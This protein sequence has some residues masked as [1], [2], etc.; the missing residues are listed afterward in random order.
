MKKA[1]SFLL[2]VLMCLTMSACGGG[3]DSSSSNSGGRQE[4]TFFAGI[5]TD[6]ADF[7]QELVDTYNENQGKVDGVY[8]NYKPKASNY[9]AD[10]STVFAGTSVPDVITLSDQYFKGY[11]KQNYLYNIDEL[12]KASSLDLNKMPKN[13][14]AR[15]RINWETKTA[16]NDNDPL[17]GVP[18]GSNPTFLYYNVDAFEAEKI[19]II[20]ISEEDLDNYNSSNSTSYMPH[21][22]AEYSE[23]PGNGLV[24]ST[25][26]NG[27]TVYK[28]FNNQIPMN[29]SELVNISKYLTKSY[30]PNSKTTYGFLSEW[31]FSHGWSVGGDCMNWD[32]SANQ[33]VFTLGNE[34]TNYLVTKDTTI[35]GH[36][37]SAGDILS[38]ADKKYFAENGNAVSDELYA[39]PSQYD[40]FAEFCALSQV[41]GKAVDYVGKE[42]YGVSPSPATL[43]SYTNARFFT[44]ESVAIVEE[45]IVNLNTIQK[46]TEGRFRWDVAPLYQYR[47]FEGGD[48]DDN[49]NLKIIGEDGYTGE[50]KYVND[51]AVVGKQAGGDLNDCFAVPAKAANPEAAVKFIAWAAGSEGQAILSKSNAQTPN[52]TEDGLTDEFLNSDLRPCENYRVVIKAQDYEDIGDWSYVE[53]GQWVNYWATILNSDVRNGDM[54][55]NKFFA[56]QEVTDYA[57]INLQKYLIHIAGK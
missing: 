44:A 5:D 52:F 43:G 17:Y 57:N 40:A 36:S 19:N 49:G 7:Y 56:N 46:S 42:G 16:G 18:N 4:I 34:Y 3:S 54:P 38:Y 47:E 50:L 6:T 31:W 15:F 35:N 24:A 41:E 8:V 1:I 32:D 30:N 9:D 20:S 27:K 13:N 29:W 55:L 10:L 51:T 45:A 23:D 48:V 28:V 22:Y 53:D 39:L 21:G 2:I 11:T 12:V 37:Y 26:I 25:N 14:V 33:Y